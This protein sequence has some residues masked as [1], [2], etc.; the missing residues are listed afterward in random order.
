MNIVKS[1]ITSQPI[2]PTGMRTRM[3]YYLCKTADDVYDLLDETKDA[4]CY[5]LTV[6]DSEKAF[7]L[8]INPYGMPKDPLETTLVRSNTF[9]SQDLQKYLLRKNYSKRRQ[10][11]AEDLIQ[12]AY[13]ENERITEQQLLEILSDRPTISRTKTIAFI[14]NEH[15]GVGKPHKGKYGKVPEL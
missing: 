7:T 1:K 10:A 13:E 4:I 2:I 11:H 9:V 12:S 6:G 5:N 15:F 3:G 8:E 14:T